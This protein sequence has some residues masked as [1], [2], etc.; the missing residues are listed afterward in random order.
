MGI[1][2]DVSGT[3]GIKKYKSTEL[4][5]YVDGWVLAGGEHGG[6]QTGG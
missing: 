5:G 2:G 3:S 6:G 4:G 1:D